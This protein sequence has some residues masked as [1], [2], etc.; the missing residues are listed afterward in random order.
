MKIKWDILPER[1]YQSG[2]DHG[3]L[4]LMKNGKYQNGIP[5]NGLTDVIFSPSGAE[6][7]KMFADNIIYI[8]QSS[9]EEN[10]ATIECYYTPEEFDWCDGTMDF[11]IGSKVL[12]QRRYQFGFVCRT[13]IGSAID[14]E[15]LGFILHILYNCSANPSETS[16]NTLNESPE[17]PTLS[18]EVTALGHEIS[19]K[20]PDGKPWMI[21]SHI[22]IDSRTLDLERLWLIESVLF[23]V[24]STESGTVIDNGNDGEPWLPTP[25]RLLKI[26]GEDTGENDEEEEFDMEFKNGKIIFDGTSTTFDLPIGYVAIQVYTNGLYLSEDVDYTINK[27]TSPNTITFNDVFKESDTGTLVYLVKKGG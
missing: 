22:E 13:K 12:Q 10:A 26:L 24:D 7:Q 4:Y 1:Y 6:K 3:V 9:L 8:T 20:G 27:S 11:V 15:D 21:C 18:Y 17:A 16:H 2:V 5:W 14:G 25:N 19:G 23:G